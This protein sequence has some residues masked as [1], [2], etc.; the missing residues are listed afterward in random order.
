[1][2]VKNLKRKFQSLFEKDNNYWNT[3]YNLNPPQ[4]QDES[5]FARYI[6]KYLQKGKILVDLGCGNGR[7]SLF[8]EKLGLKVF[9]IDASESAIN[10]LKTI[11][12]SK[13]QFVNGDFV[14]N[15]IIYNHQVDYFY[16]RFTIHAI[17]K[18]EETELLKNVINTLVEGGMF[19]IEVRSIH[20]EKYGKGKQVEKNTYLLD[21]HLRRFVDMEE[22]L[23][24]LIKMG[25]KI[26]YA[27]EERGFAPYK[28]EDSPIIRIVAIKE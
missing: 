6:T 5:L 2:I 18:N 19:F 24:E 28:N 22:L 16:S 13:I 17:D 20:D 9:A 7:D 14:H 10:A 25:F 4:T 3:Y 27:E 8:F 26:R 21:G 23:I 1:M 12:S 11:E 15:D